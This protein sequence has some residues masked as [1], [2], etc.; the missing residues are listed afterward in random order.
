MAPGLLL[1]DTGDAAGLARLRYPVIVKPNHEGSSKGIHGI[2]ATPDEARAQAAGLHA[3]YGGPA[4]VEE[5]L[6][7]P[8]VTIGIAGNGVSARVL[9][10]MEIAPAAPE[11]DFVYSLAAKRDFRRRIRYHNPPR[12]PRATRD[13]L[14]AMALTGFRL[15][16]CRD[17]ARMD[18][19][20]DAA[21]Q[22]HFLECNPLPG[23][24]P[25]TGDLVILARPILAHAPLV[26]GILAAAASR[27]GLVP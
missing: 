15:L 18:F 19:R 25:E 24:D 14:A 27:C 5:F 2:A 17:V 9:G 8:E 12:L 26:Q 21:G 6:P 3:R 22:P 7:G 20:L 23:L 4:L 11:P 1:Q 10:L 13:R 16:G